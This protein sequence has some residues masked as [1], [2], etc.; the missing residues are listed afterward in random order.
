M[1]EIWLRLAANK[2]VARAVVSAFFLLLLVLGSF[3]YR[4]YGMAY[5]EQAQ[6]TIGAVSVKYVTGIFAPGLLSQGS[7]TLPALHEFY[8]KEYGVGFEA[9]AVLLDFLLKLKD[10]RDVYMFRHLLNFLF[11][12]AG[13]VAM[14][15][16]AARR[17]GDW[18]VG[19]LA[20]VL[21]VLTPRLFAEGF[22]NSKDIVFMSAF[23]VAMYTAIS[24]VLAPSLKNAFLHAAATAFAI[25]VR[26]MGLLLVIGTV[27]LIALRLARRELPARETLAALL[28]YVLLVTA[29]TVAGWPYLWSNPGGNLLAAFASMS[30]YRWP[31]SVLYL[32]EL[33]LASKLPWH[34]PL[35]W[36]VISTPLLYLALF[37]LGF[38]KTC[39][40]VLRSK[41][42]LWKSEDEL[43]D[44]IFAGM[45]FAPIVA[46]ILLHAVLYNGWRHL[47]FVYPMFLMMAVK[48]WLILWNSSANR[49]FKP[50]IAALLGLSLAY[51]VSWMWANHPLQNV[52]FNAIA[53]RDVRHNFE[54]DYW[55]LG[56]RMALERLLNSDPAPVLHVSSNKESA[57]DHSFMILRPAQRARLRYSR[58]PGPNSY[59]ITNYR[60][61]PYDVGT[62]PLV[63]HLTT[64]KEV[65]VSV[66]RRNR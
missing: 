25:D 55:G 31:G 30:H 11:F 10:S 24:L 47:Y 7:G 46:I 40:Q 9:P 63:F 66:F 3:I 64:G 14:F 5:D 45:F 26:V 62:G 59:Y 60:G 4:D 51:T 53:G 21:L 15:G 57:L 27:S 20:A 6:R 18:R 17:F 35:V 16:L 34:Y 2:P 32:G 22:Y 61:V 65:A 54:V 39:A 56:N 13:V 36:I 58:Q 29:F 49:F 44:L 1:A 43:Q 37:A 8:D 48:G 19:L 50:A 33:F 23:A 28:L 38:A 41:L 52:Y 42:R 12:F